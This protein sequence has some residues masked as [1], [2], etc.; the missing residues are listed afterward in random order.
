M[1]NCPRAESTCTRYMCPHFPFLPTFGNYRRPCFVCHTAVVIQ[2]MIFN[3][4]IRTSSVFLCENILLRCNIVQYQERDSPI[5]ENPNLYLIK[6][7]TST[8]NY[9]RIFLLPSPSPSTFTNIGVARNF[10]WG[11]IRELYELYLYT[12]TVLDGSVILSV[13]SV[14]KPLSCCPI[15]KLSSFTESS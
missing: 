6:F 11:L 7:H 2:C 8:K 3:D 12:N 10:V 15:S 9:R 13:R 1:P 14:Y 5:S 4:R